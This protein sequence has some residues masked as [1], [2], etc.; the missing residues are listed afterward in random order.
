M[1][2]DKRRWELVW[3]GMTWKDRG[4]IPPAQFAHLDDG[5]SHLFT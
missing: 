1:V 4:E 3:D 2:G 5:N